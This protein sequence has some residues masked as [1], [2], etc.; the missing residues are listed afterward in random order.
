MTAGD[1]AQRDIYHID[2]DSDINDVI[3]VMEEHQ[4]R[5]LPV[6]NGE[7]LVGMISEADIATPSRTCRRRV[8]RSYLRPESSTRP[9]KTYRNRNAAIR[10]PFDSRR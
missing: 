9:V 6:L 10:L 3:T 4:I 7:K 1:L 8:R 2:A 5:R